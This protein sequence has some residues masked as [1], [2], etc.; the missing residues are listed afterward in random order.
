MESEEVLTSQ[1]RRTLS[2]KTTDNGIRRHFV[3]CVTR[4]CDERTISI[5]TPNLFHA[6]AKSS[7]APF[8]RDNIELLTSQDWAVTEKD[9]H[10]E[11]GR[12]G[13]QGAVRS[14]ANQMELETGVMP[15]LK[16]AASELGSRA[17]Q[18]AVL[19]VANQMELKSGKKATLKEAATELGSRGNE[20]AVSSVANQMELETGKK[21]TLKEAATEL[22]SRCTQGAVRRVANQI[23]LKTGVMPSLEAAAFELNRTSGRKSVGK[24]KGNAVWA[25]VVQISGSDE[26]IKDTEKC[27]DT[28]SKICAELCHQGIGLSFKSCTGGEYCGMWFKYARES[29]D[30]S[31]IILQGNAGKKR[32]KLTIL[33]AK[34][35]DVEEVCEKVYLKE[36]KT[37]REKNAKKSVRT[38]LA[39]KAKKG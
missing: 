36:S 2:I 27:A 31:T 18:G 17:N 26:E 25:K 6:L 15:T 29:A 35:T 7:K 13:N 11:N 1:I 23:E 20:G 37:F 32:W 14:I 30:N 21:A 12:R 4:S 5:K 22:G 33:T 10:L 3:Q 9:V 19:S 38:R 8:V 34:P 28:K 24:P 16:K 39:K